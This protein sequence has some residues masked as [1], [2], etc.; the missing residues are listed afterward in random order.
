MV[1]LT[2]KRFIPLFDEIRNH[3]FQWALD[4]EWRKLPKSIGIALTQVM[5]EIKI[6]ESL[7][8]LGST[9]ERV[10]E[11]EAKSRSAFI[12]L[13]NRK[14]L[15]LANFECQYRPSPIDNININ[16]VIKTIAD[17]GG[18]YVE[19][20][21]WFFD[22]FCALEENKKLMPPTYG[23]I[24]SSKIV[25]KFLFK[26]KDTFRLRK[27]EIYNQ[28]T[29]N[30]LIQIALPLAE[31]RNSKELA[32]KTLEFS[33]Q[34]ITITKF[35]SILKA[36]AEKLDDAEAKAKCAEIDKMIEGNKAKHGA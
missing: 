25:S 10:D 11:S 28:S 4:D 3:V 34:K 12:G 18:N 21:E 2:T 6:H 9:D 13:F 33:N 1:N 16:R 31:R 17:E 36:F 14:F 5:N 29:R 22:E 24:C 30:T 26:M 15:K 35:Y 8:E 23:L 7:R 20:V 32:A 27:D 19:Y